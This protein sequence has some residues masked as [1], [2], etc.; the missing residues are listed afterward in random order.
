MLA[1]TYQVSR[2]KDTFS[3]L[4]CH[5]TGF[6]QLFIDFLAL[7]HAASFIIF[8]YFCATIRDPI[9]TTLV[10]NVN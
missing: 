10:T 2:R 6:A 3:L 7:P 8:G 5:P 4:W 1:G 9:A